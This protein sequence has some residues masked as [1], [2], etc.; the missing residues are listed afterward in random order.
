MQIRNC[1]IFF[2][3]FVSQNVYFSGIAGYFEVKLA[4]KSLNK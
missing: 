2:V 3:T 1:I 4:D